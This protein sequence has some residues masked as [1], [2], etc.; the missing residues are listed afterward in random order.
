MRKFLL[1]GAVAVLIGCSDKESGGPKPT[2]VPEP[3]VTAVPCTATGAVVGNKKAYQGD[4]LETERCQDGGD[5]FFYGEE[6][7]AK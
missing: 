3:I 1:A 5:G 2:P 4:C 6:C 7:Q